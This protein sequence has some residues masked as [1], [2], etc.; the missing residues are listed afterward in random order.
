M[1]MTYEQY[2]EN[3]RNSNVDGDPNKSLSDPYVAPFRMA[4]NIWYIG[5]KRV[6]SH[7]IDTGD[8]LIVIDTGFPRT[9]FL[10]FQSI[11]EA[12][13]D[14]KDIKIILHSHGHGDHYGATEPLVSMFGCK[15]YVGEADAK[16][17]RERPER[18]S[19]FHETPVRM[20]VPDVELKDGDV[21]KLGN[22]TITCIATP[23]HSPGVFS[24]FFDTVEDGKTYR[25]GTFGGAGFNTLYKEAYRKSGYPETTQQDFL[26][27][28]NKV[29]D[30][31]VDIV[32]ENHPASTFPKRKKTLADPLG[33]N[34]FI[35]PAEWHKNIERLRTRIT[36]LIEAGY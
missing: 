19:H 26:H 1:A 25:A 18:F 12:G 36:E 9:E 8:G 30:E 32:L 3:R 6:C 23:G 35:D 7:L 17:F 16:L 15:T 20:F 4:G 10:I 24:F 22:T 5:D 2:L 34:P 14:P 31:K 13:F 29:I 21:V 27:S 33:P 28:V 11:W